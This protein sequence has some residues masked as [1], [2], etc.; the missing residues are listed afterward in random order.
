MRLSGFS[1]VRNALDLYY[2]VVE[3]I[4]SALPICDEFVIA[5]GDSTDETTSVLRG[6]ADPKLR[7]IETTWDRDQFVRGA[8]NAV[9]T[10]IA[11][12]ACSGDWALYLQADEVLHEDDHG[13]LLERLRAYEDD[14]R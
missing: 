11:L 14:P 9:Q 6:I 10:N 4:R 5:A 7:I 12:A 13:P 3:S 8:S 1:F 2:P